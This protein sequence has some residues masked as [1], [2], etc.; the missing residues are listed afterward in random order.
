[1]PSVRVYQ[2]GV[3]LLGG[4]AY[5]YDLDRVEVLRG[6]QGTLY[7]RGAV[8]GAVNIVSRKPVFQNE[9]FAQLGL[10]NYG[11][12]DAQ[13]MINAPLSDKLAVRVAGNFLRHDGYFNNG[14][15]SASEGSV[16]GQMLFKTEDVSVLLAA[17]HY[18]NDSTAPGKVIVTASDPY[19]HGWTTP[20]APGGYTKGQYT[21]VHGQLDWKINGVTLTYI[22]S[23]ATF[24]SYSVQLLQ[25]GRYNGKEIGNQPYHRVHTQELRLAHEAGGLQVQGGLFYYNEQYAYQYLNL[26]PNSAAGTGMDAYGY[27]AASN[28]THQVF[29]LT[30]AAIFAQGTYALADALRLTL[31]GRY[32][33]DKVN[34]LYEGNHQDI[35]P[36]SN[37]VVAPF[38][39]HWTHFDW[40][41]RIEGDLTPRNLL[42]ASVTTGYRPGT[43]TIG[44]A[45][46]PETVTTYEAGSKNSFLHGALVANLSGFYSHY[47]VYQV[48][49]TYTLAN[50]DLRAYIP[51]VPATF[52]GLEAELIARPTR[53]DT[54]NLSGSWLRA[55]FDGNLTSVNPTTQ[56]ATTYLTKGKAL[57]HAPTWHVT[58]AYQHLFPLRSGAEIALSG[59]LTYQSAQTTDYDGSNYP[60]PNPLY[61][62]PSTT[63]YNASLTFSSP[64][65]R[66]RLTVYGK[67]LGNIIYKLQA[68]VAPGVEYVNDPRSFGARF[69]AK[70]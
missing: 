67:N 63:E 61:L 19:V 54:L 11:Q 53:H 29:D 70:F 55:T 40:K 34:Q 64:S 14:Q 23:Y 18:Q 43:S 38:D 42:Y 52:Y 36:G 2:D 13:A 50:G 45:F 33:Y 59:D 5:F 68:N 3:L 41:V 12:I 21:E 26:A 7:G 24:D 31:G 32:T 47:P 66:Y 17:T 4:G 8:A 58:A 16:R 56:V 69:S 46:Q 22:P 57:P 48:V 9:G 39:E 51:Q 25:Y 44:V 62:Q 37:P 35:T 27:N 28:G 65:K 15:S 6:P 20:E 1:Q 30:S 49:Q 60:A 10:A